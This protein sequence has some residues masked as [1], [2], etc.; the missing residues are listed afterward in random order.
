MAYKI[1]IT[2]LDFQDSILFNLADWTEQ[3]TQI[4]QFE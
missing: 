2:E 3:V 1:K 4:F